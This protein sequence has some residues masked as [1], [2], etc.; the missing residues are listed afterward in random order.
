MGFK[1]PFD[2][3]ELQE[4]P[5]KNPRQFDYSNKLTQFADTVPRSNTPQ[6]PHISG[7]VFCDCS[8]CFHVN[9]S[10]SAAWF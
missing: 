7:K 1:R 3:E 6:K 10:Y 2:D 5:F 4:L 8:A 9:D